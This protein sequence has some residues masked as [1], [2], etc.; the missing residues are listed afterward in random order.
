[1]PRRILS[2]LATALIVG[3]LVLGVTGSASAASGNPVGVV[4][5][6]YVVSGGV[7][8]TG[9]AL[10]G[11]A[12]TI[13]N[14]VHIYAD[15]A[16]IG[17]TNAGVNRPDIA[18][19]FPGYGPNHG[20]RAEVPYG[21]TGNHTICVYAINHKSGAANPQIGCK[22][23]NFPTPPRDYTLQCAWPRCT[24]YLNRTA[25]YNFAYG[26]YTPSAPGLIGV[27][28]YTLVRQPLGIMARS[29]YIR[30]LC[31]AFQVSAVPWDTQ[32]MF[33]YRC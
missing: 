12:P 11:D 27:A 6:Y 19:A 32:S 26:A 5:S 18:N 31:I 24:V 7:G 29:Y 9:W 17:T 23:V 16:L 13:P 28:L 3:A 10:Q 33:S 15:G 25:S 22:V 2:L 1:M 21:G 14:D 4:D 8:V 30:G 20:F